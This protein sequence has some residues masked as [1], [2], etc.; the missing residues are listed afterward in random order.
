MEANDTKILI[1]ELADRPSPKTWGWIQ[2]ALMK[3]PRAAM[4]E[5]VAHAEAALA[6]WPDELREGATWH[7]GQL[8]DRS[9]A[10][11]SPL[12]R[13]AR[14]LRSAGRFTPLPSMTGDTPSALVGL[15]LVDVGSQAMEVLAP[16]S[17]LARLKS[18][19]VEAWQA[20]QPGWA[21]RLLDG[22]DPARI[23]ALHFA[24]Q[25]EALDEVISA[26]TERDWPHLEALTLPECRDEHVEAICGAGFARRLRA[27]TLDPR[28]LSEESAPRLLMGLGSGTVVS[29]ELVREPRPVS[30][31]L[32]ETIG[33]AYPGLASLRARLASGA[34]ASFCARA[35][36][37]ALSTLAATYESGT[38]AADC[39]ALAAW[40]GAT[41]LRRLELVA[42]AKID[43]AALAALAGSAHLSGLES[44]TFEQCAF[45]EAGARALAG[46]GASLREL[47]IDR[48]PGLGD[49]GARALLASPAAATL[50]RLALP[51]TGVG[52]ETA[53][54]VAEAAS[55]LPELVEVDL[56]YGDVSI[57]GLRAILGSE[58]AERLEG[59]HLSTPLDAR[60][61]LGAKG[62]EV[63]AAAEAPR[64]RRLS[65]A[66]QDIDYYAWLGRLM[67]SA[68]LQRVEEMDLRDNPNFPDPESIGFDI[69]HLSL[70][71]LFEIRAGEGL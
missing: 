69:E 26:L 23:H 61:R 9:P 10:L 55:S 60:R 17:G 71:H 63:V 25:G 3:L 4:D 49:A 30:A 57:E 59:L 43:D 7:K 46:L 5:V 31:T 2:K 21:A 65:L 39:E 24:R 67:S 47:V 38:D 64:L 50:A 13:L 37:R 36:T 56:S 16:W 18:L 1:D 29:L 12:W 44:A 19:R 45:G 20:Y 51:E 54:A 27:L 22:L 48:V 32:A 14:T 42:G 28:A 62:F 70:P 35:E 58:L 68:V 8:A 11:R 6:A 53:R 34:L 40:P 66:A 15:H 52:D 33:G 41:A